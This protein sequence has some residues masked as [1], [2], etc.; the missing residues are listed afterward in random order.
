MRT[1]GV[2]LNPIRLPKAPSPSLLHVVID[3]HCEA[4]QPAS[5]DEGQVLSSKLPFPVQPSLSAG[6]VFLSS[7]PQ[8][9]GGASI[10]VQRSALSSKS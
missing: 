5:R 6:R 10:G 2:L 3:P 9:A 1:N 8:S 4:Q 7:P